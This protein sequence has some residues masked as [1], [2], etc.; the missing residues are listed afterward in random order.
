MATGVIVLSIP[1]GVAPDGSGSGN[2]PARPEK[3]VS[4]GTQ[5]TNSSK[6]SYVH[7]LFDPATD[8][9]WMWV[10]TLPTD[11]ASGGTLRLTW[12]TKGTSTNAVYWKGATVC[13]TVGTTDMD[14][15]VFDT[16]VTGN[17]AGASTQGVT[18]QTTLALTM[19][20]AAANVPII[21]MIGRDA[22]NA[23]DTN[24]SDACL[25]AATFEYTTT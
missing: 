15:S 16:V 21:V 3:V 8:Q 22:D 11:Y 13:G 10:F 7:L 19:T 17:G 12:A 6:A 18:T 1:G 23:S 24:A 9:H 5:T 4:S 25:L 14:A 20:G 2:A